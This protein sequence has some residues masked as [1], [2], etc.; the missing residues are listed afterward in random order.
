MEIIH[1]IITSL[2]SLLVLFLLAKLIG[3]RQV[4][5]MSLFDYI[6]GITIGSIAAEMATSIK[7][8]IINPLIAMLVYGIS[9]AIIAFA[10]CKSMPLRKLF[11]G[12]PTLLLE[13]GK[14]Y[15][16]NF[17]AAKLDINE[18]LTQCRVAG[19]FDLTQLEAAVLET[20]GQISFLPLSSLRPLTPSDMSL[21][22]AKAS[23]SISLILDGEILT[24]N[25]KQCGNDDIWLKNQLASQGIHNEKD[26]FYAAVNAQN[27]LCV[28]VKIKQ[29]IKKE[30]FE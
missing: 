26:V 5:Q 3:N 21:S 7:S 9:A 28:Y 14:L 12:T 20:N 11:S 15:E 29:K 13:H 1:I 16:K 24:K 22:P 19:Y 10:T 30:I 23:P 6:I 18:F 27:E 8:D 25:L 4:G 17:A 2:A